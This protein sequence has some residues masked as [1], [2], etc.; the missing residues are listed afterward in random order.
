MSDSR[1]L[2][3]I[4]L[5]LCL[6]VALVVVPRTALRLSVFLGPQQG[7]TGEYGTD[8]E[9]SELWA[10]VVRLLGVVCLVIAVA[11]LWGSQ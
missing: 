11:I 3:A 10:W 7:R 6:G 8:A 1:E 2:I 9:I 4:A 5:G